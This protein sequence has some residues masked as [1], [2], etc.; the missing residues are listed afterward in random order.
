MILFNPSHQ[1]YRNCYTDKAIEKREIKQ[2][3]QKLRGLGRVGIKSPALARAA[4]V[5]K[6][7]FSRA[8]TASWAQRPGSSETHSAGVLAWASESKRPGSPS[9]S[10]ADW[11]CAPGKITGPL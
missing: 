1:K 2:D 10:A 8:E 6:G 7:G 5:W 9:S 4:K 11:L 3:K